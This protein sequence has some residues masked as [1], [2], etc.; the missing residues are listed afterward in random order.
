MMKCAKCGDEIKPGDTFCGTCGEPVSEMKTCA[1]CGKTL[2]KEMKLCGYCGAPQG[3][4]VSASGSGLSIGD[5]S[6]VSGDVIGKK[7]ETNITGNATII[8]NDDET[9]KVEKC[10]V[11]GR[12]TIRIEGYTCPVCG[13]FT[14]KDCYVIELGKCKACRDNAGNE[15]ESVYMQ[16]LERMLEDDR[17]DMAERKELMGLQ[18]Q[19]GISTTRALELENIVK[20]NKTTKSVESNGNSLSSFDRLSLDK[21]THLLYEEGNAGEALSEIEPLYKKYSVNQEVF[22]IYINALAKL[23]PSGAL[24]EIKMLQAD[25]LCT[26]LV[27]I[28]IASKNKSYSL[29]E[30]KIKHAEKYWSDS[31]LLKCRKIEF[32]KNFAEASGDTSY[33]MLAKELLDS[34]GEGSNKLEKSYILKADRMIKKAFEEKVPFLTDELCESLK[35]YKAVVMENAIDY[36]TLIGKPK[37]E[38]LEL[39]AK[40]HDPKIQ[41]YLWYYYRSIG[42]TKNEFI[43]AEKSAAQGDIDGIGALGGCYCFGRGCNADVGKGLE[44]IKQSADKG[45]LCG[46]YNL[47]WCYNDGVGMAQD[48][49]KARELYQKAADKGYAPGINGIGLMYELG[50]GVPKDYAKAIEYYQEAANQGYA[51]AQCNLGLMYE[52]ARGVTQ[53]YTKAAEWYQKAAVQGQARAQNLLGLM[54]VWSRGVTQDHAKA[55]E[56]FHKAADQ[57]YAGAQ[58]N[59]GLAY[60]QARGVTQD[61]AKAAEWYRKAADQ[62][63]SD[64][65]NNLGLMY[66]NGRGVPQDYAKAIEWYQKAA[67]QGNSNGQTNIGFMYYNGYGVPKDYSKAI[68]WFQKAADKGN[69]QAQYNLGRMYENGRGVPQ[70]Y[71]KAAA[72]YDKASSNGWGEPW[73]ALTALKKKM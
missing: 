67:A 24:N 51:I 68:E 17:I 57:G 27:E 48:Y 61:Y 6:V 26:N 46:I 15:K 58:Y 16:T 22:S 41:Y 18:S 44:L 14:C 12:N 23:N 35:V 9:K 40:D 20:N 45:S 13:N 1:K 8:N 49:A 19:L 64:G 47:G 34:C 53:D 38:L 3:Q 55:N 43:W 30:E 32:Y 25:E 69:R 50:E 60:E 4:Q 39:E 42:S 11:C 56:W 21:A 66:Q 31:V 33:I 72:F 10:H 73:N 2:P 70:D 59:L 37:A 36:K 52:N 29:V 28:D 54:Y 65:Q 71:K 62:G 5:K 63:N 7:S